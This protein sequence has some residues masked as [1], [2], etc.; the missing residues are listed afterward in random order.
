MTTPPANHLWIIGIV[1]TVIVLLV[2]VV[3]GKS[4]DRDSN[5]NKII[6]EAQKNTSYQIKTGD[7]S[8]DVRPDPT[9]ILTLNLRTESPTADLEKLAS[10]LQT[11][12]EIFLSND[13]TKAIGEIKSINSFSIDTVGKGATKCTDGKFSGD[14]QKYCLSLELSV[15]IPNDKN[16]KKL[17]GVQIGDTKFIRQE[18]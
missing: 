4:Y 11:D 10:D 12:K 18:K 3:I 14:G 17:E 5:I 6:D 7:T 15:A 16:T 9:Q 1:A 2:G 8:I 13:K